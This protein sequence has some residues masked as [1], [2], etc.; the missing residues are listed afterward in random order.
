MVAKSNFKEQNYFCYCLSRNTL[1]VLKN[2]EILLWAKFDAIFAI[3][4]RLAVI[5]KQETPKT[6]NCNFCCQPEKFFK[7]CLPE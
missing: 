5:Q 4:L 6:I 1:L 3:A 2:L 7:Y